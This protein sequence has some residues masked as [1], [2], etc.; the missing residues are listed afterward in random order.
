MEISKE[1]K[2]IL[3]TFAKGQAKNIYVKGLIY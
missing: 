1:Q 2:T 3:S